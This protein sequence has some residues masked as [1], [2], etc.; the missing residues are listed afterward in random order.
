MGKETLKL[1]VLRAIRRGHDT[2]EIIAAAVDADRKLL[3]SRLVAYSREGLIDTAGLLPAP[4]RGGRPAAVYVLTAKGEELAS[5]PYV[6]GPDL[7]APIFRGWAACGSP[8]RLYGMA[9]LP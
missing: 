7:I 8:S 5:E 4:A 2:C 9:G 1:R 6:P 3:S